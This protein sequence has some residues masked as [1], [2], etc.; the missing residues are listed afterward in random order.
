MFCWIKNNK[1]LFKWE[2]CKEEWKRPLTKLIENF[3]T[4]YQFCAGNLNKFVMLLRKCVYP[5]E[6]MVSW[7][8]LN[9]T[10]LPPKKAFIVI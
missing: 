8:K 4:I 9:E 10:V 7:E 6:Y 3:P 1:L 2:K 5:Y